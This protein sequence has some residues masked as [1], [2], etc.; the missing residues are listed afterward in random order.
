MPQ[1]KAQQPE[2]QSAARRHWPPMNCR[3]A[4]LPTFFT[5]AGSNLGPPMHSP[6]VPPALPVVAA[7][8]GAGGV[9]AVGFG[10]GAGAALPPPLAH[11]T[12]LQSAG[13]ISGNQPSMAV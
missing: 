13:T 2:A 12:G 5:P 7:G 11:W 1:G 3:P 9:V 4:P 10:A 6:P 8:G